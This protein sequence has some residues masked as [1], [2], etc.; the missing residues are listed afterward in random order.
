MMRARARVVHV[1][2]PVAAAEVEQRA[3]SWRGR[4]RAQQQIRATV[5]ATVRKDA[6]VG[7]ELEGG[8]RQLQ[9]SSQRSRPGGR[10]NR[11]VVI[12]R[13]K[14]PTTALSG[15]VSSGGAS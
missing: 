8:V 7:D 15:R 1:Q 12:L 9:P 5:D 2:H 13:H 4:N 3:G 6:A 10:F 11:E 14:A